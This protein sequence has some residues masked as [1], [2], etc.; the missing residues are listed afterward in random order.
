[1]EERTDSKGKSTCE[2][3]CMQWKFEFYVYAVG[4]QRNVFGNRKGIVH[5]IER[6]KHDFSRISFA[7]ICAIVI[8]IS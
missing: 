5:H 7:N 1:M 6:K 8:S 3:P 2:E 4:S